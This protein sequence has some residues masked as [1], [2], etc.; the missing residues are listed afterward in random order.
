M[1]NAGDRGLALGAAMY[2]HHVS[3]GGS[4]RHPPR[5]DYL[6]STTSDSAIHRA[7]SAEPKIAFKSSTTS[8]VRA[9]N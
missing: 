1:P 7:L 5:H 9:R 4:R 3:L 6:G 2:G 8:R